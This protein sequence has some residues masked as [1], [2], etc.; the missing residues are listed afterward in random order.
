MSN[1]IDSKVIIRGLR[2]LSDYEYEFKMA[3]MNRALNDEIVT[4]FIL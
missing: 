3:L 1:K 4:L 2:A